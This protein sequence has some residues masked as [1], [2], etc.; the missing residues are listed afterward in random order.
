MHG[1]AWRA[2]GPEGAAFGESTA[3]IVVKS[4]VG[5]AAAGHF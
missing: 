2:G 5:L 1:Y 3:R 4:P